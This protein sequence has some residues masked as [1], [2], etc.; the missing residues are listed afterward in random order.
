MKSVLFLISVL[1][2][3]PLKAQLIS[4]E[5]AG[6]FKQVPTFGNPPLD[7]VEGLGESDYAEIKDAR[8]FHQ[9]IKFSIQEK[10]KTQFQGQELSVIS[11]EDALKL[12]EI[13]S[14][15]P[16]MPNKYLEDGCYARAHE[17]M[18]I[19]QENGL[20]F[21]KAFLQRPESGYPLLFPQTMKKGA[22]FHPSFAGWKYHANSFVMVEKDGEVVPMVFDIGVA[23]RPQTIDEWKNNLSTKPNEVKL[24]VRQK[25]Y[26]FDDGNYNS[27][28]QSIIHNLI[29]TQTLI[30]EIGQ[31]EYNFR[32]E[33]GWL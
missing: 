10:A 14:S 6:F 12:F 21:G 7:C 23:G 32:V 13:F 28:R 18:L 22:S 1:L 20:D 5:I 25:D 31:D 8:D 11:Y 3:G 19:A 27:P 16:Y 17:L 15:I 26:V 29:E 30:D 24:I 2:S 9:R 4:E 33:Q